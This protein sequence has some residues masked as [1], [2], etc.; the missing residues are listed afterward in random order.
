LALFGE[1]Y[2]EEVRVVFMGGPADLAA[3]QTYST[4]LC[5]GTHVTRTGDI[6][7]LRIVS[8]NAV[9]S[10]VRRL[11]AVTGIGALEY[12]AHRDGLLEQ[13]AAVIKVTPEQM[14]ERLTALVEDRRRLERELQDM[15]R[16]MAS[17][18]SGGAGTANKQ[19]AGVTLAARALE[20]VPARE[21]K[22]MVDSLKQEIGS[23]VV[24]IASSGDGKASLVVGV[25]ADLTERFSAVDLVRVGSE[26]L[27]GKGGGG[28]PNMAQAGGPDGEATQAALDAIE[29]VIA[30]G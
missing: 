11:E 13:A 21:L 17:G 1:K 3:K 30:A 15:R 16:K 27:G 7:L 18:E 6:G 20:D 23:G 14:P 2:G 4:E 10:G 25:T 28:R 29:A 9:A 19:V 24:A 8:E 22:G 12:V 26:A 5:G